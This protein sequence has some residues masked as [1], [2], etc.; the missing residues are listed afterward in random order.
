MIVKP[1]Y[2]IDINP[3]WI[4]SCDDDIGIVVNLDHRHKQFHCGLS[5]DLNNNAKVLHL[6]TH[7]SL[8]CDN[9]LDSFRCWIRP[10]IHKLRQE[11]VSAFCNVIVNRGLD[12]ND[13]PYGF[14]YDGTAYFDN[15]ASLFHSAN[16]SGYTCG[17]FV[18]TIFHSLSLDL[19]DISAWPSREEDIPWQVKILN[20]LL[21]YARRLGI[22]DNHLLR[23]GNEIGCPRYRPEEVSVSSA[24]YD[25]H[26]GIPA[27]SDAIIS[28]GG[29]LHTY[30]MR[31]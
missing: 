4:N 5:F 21:K 10:S 31:T 23:L 24:L 15:T 11:Q 2:V 18:L 13:I 14:S 9:N 28:E 20:T 3:E 8:A 26:N 27:N 7:N 30:M 6:E 16:C 12:F 1:P 29:L 17:T 25:N 22:S 19:I